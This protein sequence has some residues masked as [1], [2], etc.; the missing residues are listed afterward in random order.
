[1]K[2]VITKILFLVI[3]MSVSVFFIGC[4]K[5]DK[6]AN[7]NSDSNSI[8]S[9]SNQDGKTD[10]VSDMDMP[11]AENLNSGSDQTEEEDPEIATIKKYYSFLSNNNFEEA[12]QMRSDQA[13][14]S[15]EK[16][17]GW[18]KNAE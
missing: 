17:K 12:H 11:D 14:T 18:Y 4:N 9:V 15:Y 10:F 8:L 1:M 13:K 6:T 16:F 3:I 2:T 7:Q 5:D